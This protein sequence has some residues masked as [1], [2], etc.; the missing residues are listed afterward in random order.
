M[1]QFDQYVNRGDKLKQLSLYD[2][3][4]CVKM[5]RVRKKAEGSVEVGLQVNDHGDATYHRG[6]PV[7]KRYAFASGDCFDDS[8]AQIISPVPT[9]PQIVGH[10]PPS[11]PGNRPDSS[12]EAEEVRKWIADAKLFVEFYSILFLPWDSN[13]SP[14]DPTLPHLSVLPWD[15]QTSWDNFCTILNS[16]KFKSDLDRDSEM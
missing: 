10:A 12:A 3:V 4:A 9:I 8:F 16:W 1:T 11:Y 14:R 6:R 2:Y 15:V 5:I 7:S 13:F